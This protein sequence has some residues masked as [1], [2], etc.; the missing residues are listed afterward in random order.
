MALFDVYQINFTRA[1]IDMINSSGE[2]LEFYEEYLNTIMRPTTEAILKARYQ[3]KLVAQIDAEDLDGV[4][5]VGNCGPEEKIRRFD[6]MHSLS[7][8]DVIIG[9]DRI[10]YYV[11]TFGFTQVDGF[12]QFL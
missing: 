7:V 3:Y 1:Q 9:Q 12:V 2:P 6:Q 5:H 4:F 10:P 11:D 8:G